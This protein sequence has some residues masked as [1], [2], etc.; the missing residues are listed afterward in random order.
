MSPQLNH[1][2]SLNNLRRSWRWIKTNPDAL[3]KNY[4]RD[5]Y[6]AY[7]VAETENLS[8]L[9]N[10]LKSHHDPLPALKLYFP[11]KSGILRP[12]TLLTIEDQIVYQALANIIAEK[13]YLKQRK[14]YLKNTFGNIYA[15][16]KSQF[17]YKNWKRCYTAY[18]N[19]IRN[20]ISRGYVYAASFD[21]TACYDS[22]DHNVLKYFLK[23]IYVSEDVIGKLV[24]CLTVWSKPYVSDP[25]YQGH[26]IPQGPLS[27]GIISEVVLSFFDRA[28]ANHIIRY[29]R[30]VDDI[31]IYAKNEKDLRRALVQLDVYSKKI[32]LFP[33]TGKI[34]IHKVSDILSEIKSVSRPPED[35]VHP[36]KGNKLKAKRRLK[37]LSF[38]YKI[39]DANITRFKYVLG[40]ITPD[41][42]ISRRLLK[43]VIKYPHMY[44]PIF[45]YF[46]QYDKLPLEISKVLLQ[47][48]KNDDLYYSFTAELVRTVIGRLN[49]KHTGS[50]IDHIRKIT[51]L[52]PRT[53]ITELT[54]AAYSFLLHYKELKFNEIR[55]LFQENYPWWTNIEIIRYID[56]DFIGDP[57]AEFLLNEIIKF[58][59]DDMGIMSA[60]V[61]GERKYTMTANYRKVN[62]Y[63]LITLNKFGITSAKYRIP[64]GIE[65]SLKEML[66]KN[67]IRMSWKSIF[68]GKYTEARN[69]FIL[70]KAYYLTDPNRYVQIMDTI[71]DALLDNL[72]K[73]DGTVGIYRLGNFG[74]IIPTSRFAAKYPKLF[75]V[76]ASIHDA[77]L[78]TKEAHFVTKRTGRKTKNITHKYV[79]TTR[80]LLIAGYEELG[81]LW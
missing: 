66:G 73:H 44:M 69:R 40:G 7:A 24:S 26:G 56:Y 50:Y 3:F 68:A 15:G 36:V 42:E 57:S 8:Y 33:Q 75:E 9:Y 4:F 34:N 49:K 17:F 29:F 77:R 53:G 79:H 74:G 63:A 5:L 47:I 45:R 1:A 22:I 81:R 64:C 30:Y 59:D 27:S 20:T 21:L 35:S 18:S 23:Q 70:A 28:S 72:F 38:R 6:K 12:Y 48:I 37:Q 71:H 31:R 16:S 2:F 80:K 11:K 41:F 43:L 60:F 55:A 10:K 58:K 67:P 19:S 14:Y 25:I 32:G 54:T 46:K 51:K 62:N 52:S 39:D 78:K 65:Y 13:L 76:V 61:M